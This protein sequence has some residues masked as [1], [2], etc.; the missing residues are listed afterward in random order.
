MI[1]ES[2]KNDGYVII[3]DFL[4]PEV[5]DELYT[6]AIARKEIDDDYS[7]W[8]Y[9]S[10]NFGMDKGFPF[11]VLPDV[12]NAIHGAFSPLHSLEFDR[13]WAFALS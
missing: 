4:Y 5:V 3:D 1:E 9:H 2:L 7:K 6:E 10:I 11:T 13:G 8:G 12:I